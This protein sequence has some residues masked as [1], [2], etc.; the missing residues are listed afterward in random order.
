[1]MIARTGIQLFYWREREPMKY[2]PP[3]LEIFLT[4]LAFRFFG[5]AVYKDYADRLP[6]H[7]AETVLDF[8]S[9]MG[10]VAYYAVRRLPRGH[11]SC[12]DI[13]TRWLAACRKTLHRCSG[14]S[15]LQGDLY[16]LQL[17]KA[18]F[19]LIYCHFV[20]HEI[21]DGELAKVLPA[22]VELLK[23]K[24][25][26]AFREPLQETKKLGSIQCL[27]EQNGLSKKDSRVTDAPL[28]GNTLENIYIKL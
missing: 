7:G 24:G 18:T 8:G 20:L 16:T 22:L 10:T 25:L 3:N 21:P 5:K 27:I 23:P 13:S 19:D 15:F 17:P 12:A 9:G 6:L 4:W 14:V 1:M 2:E 26:L 28:M 11:L